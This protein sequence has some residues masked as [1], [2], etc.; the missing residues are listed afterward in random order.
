MW[1]Q[2]GSGKTVRGQV[3]RGG[4]KFARALG[5]TRGGRVYPAKLEELLEPGLYKS[6]TL[7]MK[8]LKPRETKNIDKGHMAHSHK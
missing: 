3:R 7:L 2:T 6:L 8:K 1:G 5:H 4:V